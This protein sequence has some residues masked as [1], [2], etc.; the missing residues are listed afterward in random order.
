MSRV[1]WHLHV[2]TRPFRASFFELATSASV[3]FSCRPGHFTASYNPN[4]LTIVCTSM[5]HTQYSARRGCCGCGC[6]CGCGCCC[7]CCCRHFSVCFYL[8]WLCK[9]LALASLFHSLN[10]FAFWSSAGRKRMCLNVSQNIFRE[11]KGE[12]EQEKGQTRVSKVEKKRWKHDWWEIHLSYKKKRSPLLDDYE[13]SGLK[14]G[15]IP[16]AQWPIMRQF[17][18]ALNTSNPKPAIYDIIWYL[19]ILLAPVSVPSHTIF[20]AVL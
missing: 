9:L 4:L 18:A 15:S 10:L 17:G 6:G 19:L 20:F 1:A 14:A 12:K 3:F 2:P 5:R 16:L 11:T 8:L 7:C 13:L